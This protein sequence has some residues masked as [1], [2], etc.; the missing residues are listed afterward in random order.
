[1]DDYLSKPVSPDKLEEKVH[2]WMR[3]GKKNEEAK[4]ATG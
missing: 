2:R 4:V 3:Q 1:M